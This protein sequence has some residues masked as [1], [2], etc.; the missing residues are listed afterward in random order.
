MPALRARHTLLLAAK[1]DFPTW[2][3]PRALRCGD[4]GIGARDPWIGAVP[5]SA[6]QRSASERICSTT[7]LSGSESVPSALPGCTSL[8]PIGRKRAIQPGFVCIRYCRLCHERILSHRH[9]TPPYINPPA[10]SSTLPLIILP[11][12]PVPVLQSQLLRSR[13]IVSL[14]ASNSIFI[15]HSAP[16]SLGLAK[17]DSPSAVPFLSYSPGP[18]D[19]WRG[20]AGST[21]VNS[22]LTPTTSL[23]ARRG[24]REKDLYFSWFRKT[25]SAV[26]SSQSDSFIESED[27]LFQDLEHSDSPL[28]SPLSPQYHISGAM[29]VST[30]PIDIT[31]PARFPSSSPRRQTSTLTSALQGAGAMPQPPSGLTINGQNNRDPSSVALRDESSANGLSQYSTGA[32]PIA[33]AERPRKESFANSLVNGSWGGVSVGSW[34]RDEYVNTSYPVSL[35]SSST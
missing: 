16:V 34:I 30:P 35:N 11:I 17:L 21:P 13:P 8:A 19:R 3:Q 23:P 15:Y 12:T 7:T 1:L 25:P 4:L 2:K 22:P 27:L 20:S 10:V 5:Y 14:F 32:Q 24:D 29:S 28:F 6:Q 33:M 9:F 31:S 26:G 18:I